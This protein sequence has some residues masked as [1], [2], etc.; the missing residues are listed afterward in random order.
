MKEDASSRKIEEATDSLNTK[1]FYVLLIF[2]SLVG[3]VG[4]LIMI[5]FFFLE[6]LL[7]G[8]IWKDIP[9]DS[10]TPVFNP[11]ILVICLVGGLCVGLIRYYF[12]GEIVVGIAHGAPERD[13]RLVLHQGRHGQALAGR[14]DFG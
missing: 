14:P 11:W 8:V 5:L 10:L 7:I 1:K 3:V 9:V 12:Q 2:V 6:D 4:A 13:G